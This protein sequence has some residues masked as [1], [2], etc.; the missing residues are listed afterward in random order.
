MLI[1]LASYP[2]SGNT[3]FRIVF[4]SLFGITTFSKYNDPL[5][6]ELEATDTIGHRSLPSP[7]AVLEK[8]PEQSYVV[9]THDVEQDSNPAIYLVRDGRAAAVSYARYLVSFSSGNRIDNTKISP[10]NKGKILEAL[11]GQSQVNSWRH[12]YHTLKKSITK[13]TSYLECLTQENRYQ[14]TLERVIRGECE[15]GLWSEHVR[16]W[17]TKSKEQR[18]VRVVRFE[19][20]VREPMGTVSAA[21]EV[22]KLKYNREKAKRHPSFDELHNKWPNFFR[23]GSLDGWRHEMPRHLQKLFWQLHGDALAELDYPLEI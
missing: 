11:L 16:A 20:L 1:W 18:N 5:F 13:R 22:L 15:Y 21:S 8:D 23:V 3:Y 7:L 2:R 9:K 10:V 14:E 6:A 12:R 17:L 19:D 4:N